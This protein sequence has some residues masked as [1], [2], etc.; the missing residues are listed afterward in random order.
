MF[1]IVLTT[2]WFELLRE[3]QDKINNTDTVYKI[4]VFEATFVNYCFISDFS[5]AGSCTLKGDISC[6]I[7]F[8]HFKTTDRSRNSPICYF[9]LCSHNLKIV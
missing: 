9:F 7:S 5:R 8:V 3:M 4:P 6:P 1:L 2:K